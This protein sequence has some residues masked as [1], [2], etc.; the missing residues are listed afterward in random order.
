M[1]ELEPGMSVEAIV[2]RSGKEERAR[3]VLAAPPAD[4]RPS[5]LGAAWTR[6]GSLAVVWEDGAAAFDP[7][8][9]AARWVFRDVAPGARVKGF[10]GVDGRLALYEAEAAAKAADGLRARLI[11]LNDFTGDVAWAYAM[12]VEPS[13]QGGVDVEARLFGRALGSRIALLQTVTRGGAREE[14]LWTFPAE[15]GGKPDKRSLPGKLAAHAVDEARGVFYAVCEVGDRQDR[16]LLSRP[17]EPDRKDFKP[18]DVAL[19]AGELSPPGAPLFALAVEGDIVCVLATAGAEHRIRVFKAGQSFR[20]LSLLEGRTL[21]AQGA[22][23]ARLEGGVLTVYNVPRESGGEPRAFLTAFRPDAEDVAALTLWDAP[24]PVAASAGA[25]WTLSSNGGRL[26]AL[27]SLQ[28]A[29]PGRAAE[30]GVAAVYDLAAEGYLRRVRAPLSAHPEPVI[31]SRGR[32]YV[33][34]REKTE[35]YP[36]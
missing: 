21:P 25:V 13:A 36:E 15:R 27:A 31:F 28:G 22:P 4:A 20:A 11:A 8:S 2:T 16:I 35:A 6:D 24:A 34:A 10:L 1:S 18:M 26:L 17:L 3:L 19:K 5:I 7:G 33:M 9:G 29:A 23:T 30:G 32:L 14:Y 12:D